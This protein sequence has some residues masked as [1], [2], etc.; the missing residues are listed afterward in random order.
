[1]L[2]ERNQR[3]RHRHD[4]RG[5]HVH[6]LHF[7]GRL[8]LELVLE[9]ARH[10]GVGQFERLVE[11]G[12]GL[13]DDVVALLDRREVVDLVGRLAVLHFAIGGFQK[14]IPIRSRIESQRIDQ[15]DVR[16]LRRLDRADAA[17]VGRMHVAHF[18]AGALARQAA[19][20]QR[21]DAPLMRDLGQRI[22]LVHELRQLAR[23][24]ELLDRR[25]DRLGVDQVVR[26]QVLGFRLRQA[27][28]DGALD[29]HQAGAELV[30]GQ[31]AHRAHAPVAEMVDV[32]DLAAA[33]AQL[34]QDADHFDDVLGAERQAILDLGLELL[35][36][37]A[38]GLEVVEHLVDD[39][40]RVGLGGHAFQAD[41]VEVQ[42]GNLLEV[43]AQILFGFLRQA[44]AAQAQ[45]PAELA[46][47]VDAA[48]EFHAA[49]GREVIALL[50]EEQAVEQRL[51][52]VFRRRL[53]G[54]HHA[55][56]GDA[57]GVHV[58]GLVGA[59]RL[60]DVGTLVEVVGE[61]RLQLAD[62]GLAQ[63]AE[64]LLGD[65]VVGVG[66]DLAGV[67]VDDVVRER[68]ADDEV[69]GRGD[70]L[71]PGRLHVADVLDGDALVLRDQGLARL[72]VDVEARHFAA[73]ALGHHFEQHMVLL[74][75]EGVEGE[76]FLE[77]ALG[78]V[79]ERLQQDGDRHLA[80]PVD[81]EKHDVLRVELEVEPG[82]AVG[83]HARRE[84]QLAAGVGL[85]AV[86]LEE[87]ARRAV[88][89]RDD[90]ALGAV[91]DERA[92][93]GHERNLAHVHLLLLDFLGGRLGRVLVQDHQAHLGAQRTGVGEAA[94]P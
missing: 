39:G 92:G 42:L 55:V 53:A 54:A 34:D 2:E 31:L 86:V 17:V 89:L 91:D 47:R 32:V 27:L 68:A 63:L 83:D 51:D 52:R 73:Q 93:G 26:H 57:R 6:V 44:H 1:M 88:Q 20:S 80:A 25:R 21:R 36:V 13:G 37:D 84:Q 94:L 65:L 24:E 3:S 29:A 56:D 75:V 11:R 48:V 28:L 66:D 33:V 67:L 81:T 82:A 70:F 74:D 45:L 23:A 41:L 62:L 59:Q 19:R 43:V 9:A 38:L 18:E 16:A 72:V 35:P 7:L 87:H 61:Q 5:R 79:A 12:V 71:Q 49:H 30:F 85:A 46:G 90:D 77:D 60:R 15:A 22:G 64:Q 78:R 40:L 76:E 69:V 14:P 58:G 50:G 10:Q 4:L 8:E